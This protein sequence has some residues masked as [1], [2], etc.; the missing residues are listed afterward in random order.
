MFKLTLLF[1]GLETGP[2]NERNRVFFKPDRK[3]I[4]IEGAFYQMEERKVRLDERCF[5]VPAIAIQKG[6]RDRQRCALIAVNK[7]VVPCD[8]KGV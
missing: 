1:T 4:L 3:T 8:S 6:H 5:D 7:S 2:W